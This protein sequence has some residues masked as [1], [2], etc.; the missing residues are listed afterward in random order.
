MKTLLFVALVL[1]STLTVFGGTV[2]LVDKN[3]PSVG[4]GAISQSALER[5]LA[6]L[7]PRF[8]GLA[9]LQR[10]TLLDDGDGRVLP[11]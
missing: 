11:Y 3:L 9:E 5:A 6:P 8:V 10:G 7:N 2:V 4:N 1:V